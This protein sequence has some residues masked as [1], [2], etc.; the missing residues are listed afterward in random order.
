M[1]AT[2]VLRAHHTEAKKLFAVITS[3]KGDRTGAAQELARKLLAHMII[4]QVQF[5]PAVAALDEDV[6]LE[7]FEEHAVARYEIRRLIEALDD[8]RFESRATTLK[9]LIE[10]HVKEE[11][12]E[13]FPKVERRMAAETQQELGESMT[14]LFES[15]L[16]ADLATLMVRSRRSGEE[17][18]RNAAE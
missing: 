2:D 12:G 3:G 18:S 7:S 11:E 15:L 4:E 9:E 1:K 16:D 13:L 8:P 6:V 5:Y 10:H 17:G 14:A